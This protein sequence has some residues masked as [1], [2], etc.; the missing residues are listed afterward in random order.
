MTEAQRLRQYWK[1][2]ARPFSLVGS[3]A[4]AGLGQWRDRPREWK[5]GGEGYGLRYGSLFAEHIAFETLSFGASSVFHEDNRYV[6]SGQSGF[7]NRVGYALRSTFVARGDD[8]ARRI[9]RSRI[10]AFA[11]AALLS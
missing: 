6:P 4:G 2:T 3:A 10:L 1:D 8:G 5:Q 7:G 11:G 9:S